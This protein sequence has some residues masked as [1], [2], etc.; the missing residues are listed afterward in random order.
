MTRGDATTTKGK[1]MTT[2]ET[3]TNDR[4]SEY[5]PCW[6][7]EGTGTIEDAEHGDCECSACDGTGEA[8]EE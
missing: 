6:H 3:A 7:C 4:T 5:F 8:R 1:D 2:N